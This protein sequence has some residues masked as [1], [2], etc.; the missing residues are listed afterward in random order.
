MK[1]VYD[2]KKYSSYAFDF[3]FSYAT[4][5]FCRM[6]KEKAGWKEFNFVEDK[7]RFNDL[8]LVDLIKA[9]FPELEMDQTVTNE[10]EKYI[11]YKKEEKQILERAEEIKN[12]KDS[13]LKIR[14]IK[15]ELYPFQKIGVEFFINNGGRG[16][17]SDTM[18]LGKS[19]QAL[20]YVVHQKFNKVL[21]I[22]PAVVK[23]SWEKE[24]KIWTGL[25]AVVFSSDLIKKNISV[26][27]LM[28][29][30]NENQIFI[31]NYDILR[32]FFTLL[33]S[34]KWDCLICDE[35]HYIKNPAAIR[36]KMVKAIGKKIPSV[37][38]LSGTPLLSRPIELFSGLNLLDPVNWCNRM[39]YSKRYCEGHQSH[40]GW[41]E[42]GSSNIDELQ[43][44]ISRYFLRRTK[45]DVLPD[46]PPKQFIDIPIELSPSQ[47]FEYELMMSD[48]VEYLIEYK[49]KNNIEVRRSMQAEKL[50]R[51]GE[52][53]RVTSLGKI[54]A[55]KE[56]IEQ[57]I[58]SGE[59]I[60]VFS[61]YNEP[62]EKLHEEFNNA[63]V[64]ITG[65]TSEESR[66]AAIE[67]FQNDPKVKVFF[68]GIKSAGVGITL[69]AA[70]SVLFMDYSWVPADH[71]QAMDRCHRIGQKAESISVYYLYAINTIDEKMK[72]ILAKKKELFNKLVDDPAVTKKASSTMMDDLFRELES[73][74]KSYPQVPS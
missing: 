50:V 19:A 23:L 35:F 52:L 40:W 69:T 29:I 51:L 27:E 49:K 46:L 26:I 2:Q 66:K 33:D 13:D 68:G 58:D 15:K 38:L 21:V 59:K 7:W 16:I 8:K 72:D 71:D 25:K 39:N 14:G 63:S 48:F 43:Q 56:M 73:A 32:T 65:K 12:K 62:L 18:G 20:A 17:L 6:I 64:M 41:D 9:R 22:A 10:Y 61:C 3:P 57:I 67:S 47:K 74:I 42:R 24:V 54:E 30:L 5:D 44:K 45:E 37:L 11:F 55:A 53:R 4:L 36:T 34:V 28:K 31:I 60:L 1:I 70:S